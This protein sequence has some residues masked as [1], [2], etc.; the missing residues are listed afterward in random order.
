MHVADADFALQAYR[1][2]DYVRTI[3]MA[4]EIVRAGRDTARTWILLVRSHANR[5]E[6]PDAARRSA[7]AVSRFPKTPTLRALL[8]SGSGHR[9]V[10][11]RWFRR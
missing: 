10:A 1:G 3:A 8:P 11:A 5:G 7:L 4:N 2:G 6:L 9:S